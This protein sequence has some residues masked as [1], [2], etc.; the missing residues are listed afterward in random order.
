MEKLKSTLTNDPDIFF[1][2]YEMAKTYEKRIID[3]IIISSH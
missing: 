1:K 3:M 2:H